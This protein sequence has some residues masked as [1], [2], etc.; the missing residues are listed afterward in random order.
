M[1][2][3]VDGF[4]FFESVFSGQLNRTIREDFVDVHIRGCPRTRLIEVDGKVLLLGSPLDTVTL[5]HYAENRARMRQK[6]R[7]QYSYPVLREGQVIWIEVDDFD[8]GEPHADYS[9][10][11]IV[12]EYLATGQG[13]R[14]QVGSAES[15]LLDAADL[16]AFAI[17]WL[18]ARYG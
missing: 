10:E 2:V 5:L 7:V 12:T 13:Q 11:Q 16:T 15:Y 17:A 1:I 8:T 6:N 18:E 9:F 3:R 4:L 14:G